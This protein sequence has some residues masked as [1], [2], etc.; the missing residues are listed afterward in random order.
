[1]LG[2]DPPGQSMSLSPASAPNI[3]HPSSP[4][5]TE[6][7]TCCPQSQLQPRAHGPPGQKHSQGPHCS[8]RHAGL[9]AARAGPQCSRVLPRWH[10]H[11]LYTSGGD[12]GTALR[13]RKQPR[14]L[15]RGDCPPHALGRALQAPRRGS[16]P[17]VPGRCR[18]CRS[19][20]TPSKPQLRHRGRIVLTEAPVPG[21]GSGGCRRQSQAHIPEH[22]ASGPL[23]WRK[24]KPV[25]TAIKYTKNKIFYSIEC[26]PGLQG[27]RL[28]AAV[29]SEQ[30]G[31]GPS[32][33]LSISR[34]SHRHPHP[35]PTQ[36]G[37]DCPDPTAMGILASALWFPTHQL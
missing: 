22:V 12:P 6:P 25:D 36:L 1:M 27:L 9:R 4:C 2:W 18:Q 23:F 10:R 15:G 20:L 19:W 30:R 26:C 35:A 24:L 21:A 28:E 34:A 16:C 8:P 13:Q 11:F 3:I 31:K 32:S 7:G 14:G 29:V 33:P 17:R 5:L 37:G